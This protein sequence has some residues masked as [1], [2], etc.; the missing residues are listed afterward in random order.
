L[1]IKTECKLSFRPES[2]QPSNGFCNYTRNVRWP[3]IL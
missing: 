3:T 1:G 2:R